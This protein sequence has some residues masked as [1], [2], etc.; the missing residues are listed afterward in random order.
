[1][2][3]NNE[4]LLMESVAYVAFVFFFKNVNDVL[5]VICMTIPK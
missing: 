3:Q 4:Y 1:M 2:K 5:S